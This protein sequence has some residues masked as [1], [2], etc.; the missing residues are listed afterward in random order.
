MPKPLQVWIKEKI[1]AEDWPASKLPKKSQFFLPIAN[2]RTALSATTTL[3]EG[4]SAFNCRWTITFSF[5]FKKGVAYFTL[6]SFFTRV[7]N[8]KNRI[9]AA[10]REDHW[11]RFSKWW[12]LEKLLS[13]DNPIARNAEHT[14]RLPV[15]IRAPKRR[16]FAFF[17]E[18]F[19]NSTEKGCKTDKMFFDRESI[20]TSGFDFVTNQYVLL[21][22]LYQFLFFLV[23]FL[24]GS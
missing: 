5:Y 11:V 4:D 10:W 15:Q 23:V 2:G 19:E 24:L 22:S 3:T 17:H 9:F 6:P 1:T 18:G 7:S 20:S 12:Y 13:E 14:V 8:I 16:V 21:R